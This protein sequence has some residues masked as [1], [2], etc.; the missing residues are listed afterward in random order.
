M[1]IIHYGRGEFDVLEVIR[2]LFVFVAEDSNVCRM[3]SLLP[4]RDKV[5]DSQRENFVLFD[6]D[7]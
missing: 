2:I 4:V 6:S 1:R 3:W 7:I 5:Q